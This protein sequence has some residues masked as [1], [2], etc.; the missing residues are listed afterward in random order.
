MRSFCRKNHVRKIPLFWGWFLGGGGECRF[1][2]YGRADFSD[3][4]PVRDTPHI[5][6]Y[7]FEVVS[8]R[9]VSHPFCLVFMWCRASIAEIPFLWG[10]GGV[11]HLHF[12]CSLRG[13]RSIRGEG[14]SHPIG[15][16]ETPRIPYRAIG[17]YC[18]DSL[19]VSRNTGPRR[20]CQKGLCNGCLV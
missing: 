3:R 14:V 13:K 6:Q 10:G 5:A 17:W 8:Q 1:Y 19:A 4:G 16:V 12:A 11:S 20:C 18:W 15:H 9:G 2:F 7:L